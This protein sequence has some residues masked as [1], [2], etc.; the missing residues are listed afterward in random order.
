MVSVNVIAFAVLKRLHNLV[1]VVFHCV[2]S[3]RIWNYSGPY[4]PTFGLNM[5]KYGVNG[6]KYGPE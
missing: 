5:E 4:F 6:G 2:K 1:S 3:V